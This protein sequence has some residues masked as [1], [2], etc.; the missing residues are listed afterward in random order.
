MFAIYR[1]RLLLYNMASS[2]KRIEYVLHVS[3]MTNSVGKTDNG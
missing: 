3:E 2:L 1:V